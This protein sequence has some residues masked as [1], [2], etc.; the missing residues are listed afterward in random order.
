MADGTGATEVNGVQPPD[1]P[2]A[3]ELQR[4]KELQEKIEKVKTEI[5]DIRAQLRD[6]E[7]VLAALE[8]E[9]GVTRF[10]KFKTGVVAGAGVAAVA[11]QSLGGKIRVAGVAAGSRICE[12]FGQLYANGST[13]FI[14]L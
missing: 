14:L 8:K 12:C 7:T 6:K 4:Q 9:Q 2:S 5:K 10:S 11:V 13:V 1:E 3:E